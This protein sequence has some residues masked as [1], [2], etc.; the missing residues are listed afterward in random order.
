MPV[1]SHIITHSGPF[2]ADDVLAVAILLD[3]VPTATVARTRDPQQLKEGVSDPHTVMVDVGWEYDPALRNFDHHQQHFQKTRPNGIP[4][5]SVGL[6][7]SSFGDAW[8]KK[9]LHL[10]DPEERAYI[11]QCVDEEMISSVD[12]FDCGVVEG[13]HSVAGSTEEM[14]VPSLADVIG[15]Y[16]P[17]WFEAAEFDT[18]FMEAAAAASELL[19]RYAWRFLGE[20]RYRQVVANADDGSPVLVLP[21][22]GPW[23][24]FVSEQHLAVIFPAVGEDGWL[25]Q[26]VGDPLSTQ[27]PP[28]LRIAYPQTW[29][30][31]ARE[32][33]TVLSGVPSATFCHRA[34]F[35]AGASDKEGALALAEKLIT[36]GER[37]TTEKAS[38]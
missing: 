35:I 26:A 16:N 8:L 22:A 1:Y 4:Y 23:R 18:R 5:A 34:G 27:F 32:E 30:G 24:R 11:F 29:R 13:T 36:H 10:Q 21:T 3:L 17:A 25:V 31:R 33:L 37:R 28:P 9:V 2:H 19:R 12:A 6:V 15:T 38:S 14:R 7:W 20:V